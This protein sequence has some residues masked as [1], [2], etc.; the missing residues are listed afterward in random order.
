MKL[1][2]GRFIKLLNINKQ[3]RKNNDA[4]KNNIV[5]H[6][7]TNKLTNRKKHINLRATSLKHIK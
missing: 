1:T 7:I 4:N 2:K 3:T 5:K 6:N